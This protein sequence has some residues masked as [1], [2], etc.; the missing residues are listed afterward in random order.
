MP[1]YKPTPPLSA[2][3]ENVIY[4]R[5]LKNDEVFWADVVDRMCTHMHIYDQETWAMLYY[6]YMLPN[7]PT[8][9][10]SGRT[11][12][13]LSACYVIG[14]KDDITDIYRAKY[15]VA[16]I[17]RAGG[18]VGISLSQ[19]RPYG[20]PVKSSSHERA[21]GPVGFARTISVDAEVLTQGGSLRP[22]ALMFVLHVSHPDIRKFI[23]AK[24]VDG[25]I[26]NANISVMVDDTFM[27]AVVEDSTYDLIFNGKVYETVRARE[28]FD[29][30]A[31]HTHSNGEPG[32]LF[33]DKINS[34]TPYRYDGRF[35]EATNPCG[36]IPAPEN[37]VC[38]L[39]SINLSAFVTE[40]GNVDGALL[41]DAVVRTVRFLDNV[42]TYNQYPTQEIRDF[43]DRYRPI[44]LGVMGVADM[45]IKMG[46]RYGSQQSLDI[47]H[48]VMAVISSVAEETSIHLGEELGVPEG[49]QN[50]PR[51]R[52][53]IT[54]LSV[55][56]TGSISIIAGCSSGCEP[57]FSPTVYRTNGTGSYKA[58]H[59]MA[60]D[61]AF[62]SA[63][64]D[65]PNRVV[66]V[67]EHLAVL[68][69][70]QQYV[71]S[72]VS[73]TINMPSAATVEDVYKALMFAWH[74]P[75]I[76]GVAIYRD[77][78]RSGQVLSDKPKCPEC[79]ADV[80]TDGGCE[81]CPSCGWGK[82]SI[83]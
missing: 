11:D 18:G 72:G 16:Q 22:M 75:F 65:D 1:T 67:G 5:Y 44:G 49:C 15:H 77:G 57:H 35:I 26:S 73:K 61:P 56:P 80:F 3:A 60:N 64:N 45:L 43:V 31:E 38:N 24:S 13:G 27:Q 54:V 32:M 33:E 2:E 30:I 63:L 40:D 52:R 14:M 46:V 81:T 74:D 55:A 6:R 9:V 25:V 70:V 23:T 47:L 78:S 51:P 42:I 8:I 17:A 79:G 48:D 7:T 59:P 71:D 83:A 68:S 66:S 37:A 29:L 50:L 41:S 36:E 4:A 69:Q 82:C 28:L 19:L 62:V 20:S 34:S 21:A 12:A 58:E 39:A 76:K 53:N 10:N